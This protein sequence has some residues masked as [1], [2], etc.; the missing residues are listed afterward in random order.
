MMS[1]AAFLDGSVLHGVPAVLVLLL[2]AYVLTHRGAKSAPPAERKAAPFLLAGAALLLLLSGYRALAPTAGT[3]DLL[4]PADAAYARPPAAAPVAA[5]PPAAPPAAARPPAPLPP[6]AR[7]PVVDVSPLVTYG[8]TPLYMNY[9]LAWEQGV[10]DLATSCFTGTTPLSCSAWFCS[11]S[12][13]VTSAYSTP[14]CIISTTKYTDAQLITL[15]NARP[16]QT[17]TQSTDARCNSGALAAIF[18]G[19]PSVYA[20]FCNN[21]YLVMYTSGHGRLG[22]SGYNLDDIPYPPGGTDTTSGTCRTRTDTIN[23][24]IQTYAIPLTPVP[25]TTADMGNNRNTSVWSEGAGGQSSGWMLNSNG[26]QWGIPTDGEI[27]YTI[28]GQLM[29]PVHNNLGQYTPEK[30]E[31]DACNEHVGQGGGQPHLHGDPFGPSCL[32]SASNYT[33]VDV[34]PPHIGFA[35][36]GYWIYGR[37]LSTSAVG[38][39]TALDVCGGHVHGTYAYRA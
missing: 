19:M 38:Y 31:V 5:R 16:S 22:Y 3:T 20:A 27:G 1:Y 32:Y 2:A 11:K 21:N 13:T 30:C 14:S 35:L 37:H 39:S 9:S 24:A 25:F 29:Y 36:D 7:P 26:L 4:P 10:F 33:S 17:C 12:S 8:N 6:A 28:S 34:H 18:S 15:A 23:D